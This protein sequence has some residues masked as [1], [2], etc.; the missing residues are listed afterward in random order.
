MK[1][2]VPVLVFKGHRGPGALVASVSRGCTWEA[3]LASVPDEGGGGGSEGRGRGSEGRAGG[4]R[5][6]SVEGLI[7]KDLDWQR[8]LRGGRL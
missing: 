6:E 1:P 7:G 4:G 2:L 5:A 3:G 8:A